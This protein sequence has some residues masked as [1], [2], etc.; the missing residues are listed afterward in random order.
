M[1]SDDNDAQVVNSVALRADMDGLPMKENNP[2]LPYT[3][4]TAF[5]H[6]CGHDGHMATVLT[7]AQALV[8]NRS[9]IPNNKFVRLLF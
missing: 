2:H 9:K 8:N 3:S 6:M 5:A 7:V 1:I 4:K